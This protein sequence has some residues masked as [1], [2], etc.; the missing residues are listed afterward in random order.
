MLLFAQLRMLSWDLRVGLLDTPDL[1]AEAEAQIRQELLDSVNITKDFA[2]TALGLTTDPVLRATIN[3]F[4]SA[5]NGVATVVPA[6]TPAEIAN[7]MA[8]PAMLD[9][10]ADIE[11][12]CP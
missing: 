8:S 3:Q 2:L 6:G 12:M 10:L 9:A 7:A 4:V 11:L 5:L 1:D